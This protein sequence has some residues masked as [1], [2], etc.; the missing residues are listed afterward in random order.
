MMHD[1]LQPLTV[2]PG[3]KQAAVIS[4]DGV[5]VCVLERSSMANGQ[6][7]DCTNSSQASL[8]GQRIDPASLVALAAS[9]VDDVM[10][11]GGQIAWELPKRFVLAASQGTLL[12][13]QGPN[14]H[15]MVVIEPDC[16]TGAFSLPLEAAVER[17]HRLLRDLGRF[18][19]DQNAAAL[20]RPVPGT[21][22]MA[23]PSIDAYA[24]G[25]SPA[26]VMFT[27]QAPA[28]GS[29]ASGSYRPQPGTTAHDSS[30]GNH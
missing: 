11:A 8:E 30:Q 29:P 19:P 12:V 3:V 4:A 9:W 13:Q 23:A 2:Q 1:I 16:D 17:L 7:V 18:D 20:P 27:D 26:S 10:R 24:A 5:P 14:A 6:F 28:G 25:S 22:P 21:G 15:V